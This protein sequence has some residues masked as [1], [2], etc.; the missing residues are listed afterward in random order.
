MSR[1]REIIPGDAEIDDVLSKCFDQ[2]EKGSTYF[3]GLTYEDGIIAALDW[4]FG[5]SNVDP[6]ED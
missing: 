3:F 4:I 2:V 5:T 6:M 1:M